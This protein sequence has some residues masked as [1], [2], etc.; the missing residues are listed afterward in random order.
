[1]AARPLT[2]TTATGETL[3]VQ[4]TLEDRLKFETTLRKNPS[5]GPLKD[6]A[7]KLDPFLAWSAASRSGQVT[8]TWAEFT[9]GPQAALDVSPADL[10]AD[11]EGAELEVDGLGKDTPMEAST[12]SPSYSASSSA[13]PLG[14]GV[15]NPPRH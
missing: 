12:T 7:M 1:M 11:P 6:N 10:E 14:Y 4:P 13:V 2:I 8:Q 9:T 15:E 3:T 5:W